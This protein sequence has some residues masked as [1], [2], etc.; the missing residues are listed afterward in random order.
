M[1]AALLAV[2]M[3]FSLLPAGALAE[4]LTDPAVP[5]VQTGD[6]VYQVGQTVTV[7]ETHEGLGS[8]YDVGPGRALFGLVNGAQFTGS[9]FDQLDADSQTVYTTI[10]ESGLGEKATTEVVEIPL[11]KSW[12]NQTVN[13]INNQPSLSTET[14]DAIKS[15]IS[16][17]VNPAYL[18][19]L[20]DHPELS[21]LVNIGYQ[22]S[23]TT[24]EISYTKGETQVT[25]TVTVSSIRFSLPDISET[26]STGDKAA[27]NNAINDAKTALSAE[28]YNIDAA[29]MK[30]KVT[31]I[32]NYICDTVTYAD[33]DLTPRLYQT[34]YSGLV[35]P[36]TTVCAGY[37]KAF[38]LLCDAYGIPCVLVSGKGT[39]TSGTPEAHMWNYVKMKDEKWYAVD[40]TW[41]DQ[42]E[43]GIMTDYL[44]S[45]GS[46]TAPNFGNS[47]FNASHTA[48]GEWSAQTPYVFQYPALSD[49]AYVPAGSVAVTGVSLN[50]TALTLDVGG[51]ETLTAIVSPANAADKTVSWSSDTPAVA[52]VDDNGNVTA[53]K[54]GTATITVTTTDGVHTATCTVTVNKSIVNLSVTTPPLTY[55]D[56]G[57][58]LTVEG[59]PQYVTYTVK[60]GDEKVVEVNKDS[61]LIIHKA[62]DIPVELTVTTV[63]TDE[64]AVSTAS[65][66]VTVAKKALTVKADQTPNLSKVYDGNTNVSDF[67]LALDGVVSGDTITATRSGA[68]Y[69]SPDV[70]TGI[71]VTGGTV[72]LDGDKAA[73]YIPPAVE[74]LTGSITKA[75]APTLNPAAVSVRYSAAGEHTYDLSQLVAGNSG[76]KEMVYTASIKDNGD[77][78][79]TG[80]PTV[81]GGTLNYTLAAGM[82]LG[83]TAKITVE[84]NSRNYETATTTLTIE[85]IDKENVDAA[86]TFADGTA[87]F[88]GQTQT[89]ET[90]V[91]SGEGYTG[92]ITY[93]YTTTDGEL[94]DGKP[95]GVGTYTVAATYEDADRLGKKSVTFTIVPRQITFGL[96]LAVDPSNPP[97]YT[98]QA[99]EPAVT[100]RDGDVSV[101]AVTDYTLRY[102]DNVNAGTATVTVAGA[103]NYA[104]S[105]GTATFT[106]DKADPVITSWPQFAGTVIKNFLSTL[107]GTSNSQ[108][109]TAQTAGDFHWEVP[110]TSLMDG[111]HSY[112]MLFVPADSQNYKTVKQDVEVTAATITT[113]FTST[114]DGVWKDG[115]LTLTVGQTATLSC[116]LGLPD[117]VQVTLSG[118]RSMDETLLSVNKNSGVLTAQAPG[119][120]L[121]NY[122]AAI[123]SSTDQ[124]DIGS[125]IVQIAA[126]GETSPAPLTPNQAADLLTGLNAGDA[127]AVQGAA[128]MVLDMSRSDQETLV[129]NSSSAV[130][131]M[132]ALL[133]ASKNIPLV[134]AVTPIVPSSIPEG[135]RMSGQVS[136]VGLMLAVNSRLTAGAEVSL[137]AAQVPGR[138]AN[139]LLTVELA[140]MV[141]GAKQSGRMA[142][143]VRFS[144]PVPAGMASNNDTVDLYHLG[145]GGQYSKVGRYLVANGM[146][147]PALW[148]FSEYVVMPEGEVPASIPTP[149]PKPDT[150]GSSSSSSSSSGKPKAQ[151]S[152]SVSTAG[153]TSTASL[154]VKASLSSGTAS[155]TLDKASVDSAIEKAKESA[156]NS[157]NTA[158]LV[159]KV[160][161]ED[162]NTVKVTLPVSALKAVGSSELTGMTITSVLGDVR[163][164]RRAAASAAAQAKGDN[165]TLAVRKLDADKVLSDNRIEDAQVYELALNSAGNSVGALEKGA[166]TITLPCS[167]G[168]NPTVWSIDG[169]GNLEPVSSEYADGSV[170]FAT[171]RL[172]RYVV[173]R[174]AAAEEQALWTN[175]FTDVKE[176]DWFY[177][178]VRYVHENGL[179]SGTSDTT[180]SPNTAMTRAM[181][182][183]VLWR[184]EGQPSGGSASFSDVPGGAWYSAAVGWAS[185]EGIVSGVG[186]G[187]FDPEGNVTREQIA[188]ILHRY[189]QKKGLELPAV[190]AGGSFRD[191]AG[192]S[193]WAAESV[194]WAVRVG[195]LTGRGEGQLAP[196]ATASRAE[197]A[198]L[199]QRFQNAE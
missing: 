119:T 1:S 120:V 97:V 56:T 132:D 143:P 40:C 33:G 6:P 30:G 134:P 157:G 196:G 91:M 147:Q 127:T 129:A 92:T 58:S 124:K 140:P 67:Q 88:T 85:T 197:V 121:V 68:A 146:I 66:T 28:P 74:N 63:E 24:D 122:S 96:T 178:A 150:S 155:V 35:A 153:G 193:G 133:S 78:I 100:V 43:K 86:L 55:G 32:H 176:S 23:F 5:P 22:T 117:G 52:K 11:S 135:N 44:L 185:R 181:L 189:A 138:D 126:D 102:T 191:S 152:A 139:A 16:E 175:P 93:T 163:L 27:I 45:G 164:D 114:G 123:N 49:T 159:V 90:A 130:E 3:L 64:Y 51:S 83:K 168:G 42:G 169:A 194:D 77:G 31:A 21:W 98:G 184:V 7:T 177:E 187:R 148:E 47:T 131:H 171:D 174:A 15:W 192:I 60:S 144:I 84:V 94:K 188:A 25:T 172:G 65:T 162:C 12:E 158:Q 173:G 180:F 115:I 103:G 154:T 141:G 136:A 166:F 118:W 128:G 70:G 17:A 34:A 46:T 165:M 80:T 105:T 167:K 50:K 36:K 2:S 57:V 13:I 54:A 29:D 8:V 160:T 79:L 156:K 104:G 149:T 18:A 113:S 151:Y 101:T 182:V 20:Y 26:T 62:S 195:L 72:K 41:D 71:A 75:P 87:A 9:Y 37:A 110:N 99:I 61:N 199:I 10:F 81:S 95:W 14:S 190:T 125:V 109:G 76:F 69:A 142:F 145:T 161:G 108:A 73:N 48:S 106:I 111:T 53:V 19:L 112:P 82:E 89:H 186:D 137:Y 198:T 183:T 4:G 38:K 59:V 179:F 39:G 170:T 107:A 116:T